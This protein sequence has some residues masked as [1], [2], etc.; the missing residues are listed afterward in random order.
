ML[1]AH[2][3][4]PRAEG[5]P[6]APENLEALCVVCHGREEAKRRAESG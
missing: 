2:H 3:I 1:S 4:M 6:D 5:G